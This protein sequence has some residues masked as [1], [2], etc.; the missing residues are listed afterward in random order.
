[1]LMVLKKSLKSALRFR[2]KREIIIILVKLLLKDFLP[3]SK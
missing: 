1:M 3:H 2:P